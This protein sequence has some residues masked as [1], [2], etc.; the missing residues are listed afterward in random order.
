MPAVAVL[1]FQARQGEINKERG[2]N[3]ALLPFCFRKKIVILQKYSTPIL[4][5]ECDANR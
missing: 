1:P 3:E 4:Y 5:R 2:Q